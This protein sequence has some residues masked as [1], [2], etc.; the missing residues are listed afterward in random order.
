MP[1]V[2]LDVMLCFLHGFH[3]MILIQT[4]FCYSGDLHD[5]CILSCLSCVYNI[6]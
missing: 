5:S 1:R 3:G 4:W 6:L 2:H